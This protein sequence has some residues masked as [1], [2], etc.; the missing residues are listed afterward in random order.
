MACEFVL[1]GTQLHNASQTPALLN[2][3]SYQDAPQFSYRYAELHKFHRSDPP[4]Y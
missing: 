1:S 2:A 3:A 4:G